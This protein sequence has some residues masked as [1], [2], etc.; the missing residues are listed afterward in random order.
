V[1]I[2]LGKVE[3]HFKLQMISL[4]DGDVKGLLDGAAIKNRICSI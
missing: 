1:I 4:E 3:S 2:V